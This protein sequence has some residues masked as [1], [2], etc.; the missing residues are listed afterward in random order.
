[1]PDKSN[2]PNNFWQELKR[3]KVVRVIT[4]YAA[5]AF[6]IIEMVDI[7]AEPFG[8]PDWTLRFVFIVLC[9]GLFLSIVLS[10]V[11]DITPGGIQKTKS[12][13]ND[14]KTEIP[15]VSNSW[16]IA[17]YVSTVII[18]GLLI[19]NIIGNGEQGENLT[20]LEK[21]IAV[22]PLKNIGNTQEDEFFSDGIMETIISHLSKMKAL[23]VISRTSVEQYRESYKTAPQIASE[24]GVV[25]LLEGSAQKYNNKLRISVQ[26]I[27]ALE[28]Y[29]IWSENYDKDLTDLFLIQSEIAG[30]VADAIEIHIT[31]EEYERILNT[32][33]SNLEAYD[34]YVQ[35]RYY[36]NRRTENDLL[37]SLEY[38]EKAIKLDPE[39]AQAWSG[40]ADSYI[41]LSAYNN[42]SS[43]E[44]HI[45]AKNAANKAIELNPTLA[46]AHTTLG[47]IYAFYDH[48]WERSKHAFELALTY[49][50]SYATAHSWFGWTYVV[51]GNFELAEQHIQIARSLDPLS[52]VILSSAGWVS[53]GSG[54]YE[55]ALDL[56]K[57][58]IEHN[59]DFPRFQMWLGY[60]YMV[61]QQYDSAIIYLEKAVSLS[62]RHP[63]Y[64]ASL[65]FCYGA[66]QQTEKAEDIFREIKEQSEKRFVSNYD[67]GLTLLGT[68][69]ETLAMEY[70]EKA[71]KA[72]EIWITFLAVDP[73]FAYLRGNPDFQN[74]VYKTGITPNWKK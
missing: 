20:E 45:M 4:V 34:L 19:V 69:Q 74:I 25:Y 35:G 51:N 46:S 8:L 17:T 29:S 71:Y 24:L 9:I 73:R 27:N 49:E 23:K 52:N 53:Y 10:W 63:Q 43:E 66:A 40:L 60:N 32:P 41:M 28:D 67:I 36:W 56:F 33:T 6:V 21:S 62:Q 1:M 54:A 26:L 39:F 42:M 47:W 44:G 12:I 37:L 48:D 58:A 16:K 55:R 15:G 18:I 64:L 13:I 22:L 59:Q 65:G 7:I 50:P 31:S 3:R 38:F 72:R 14:K 68:H 5:A 2:N 57:S 30:K 11:Y 61:N 70:F